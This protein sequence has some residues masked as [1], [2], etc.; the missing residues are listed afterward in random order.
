MIEHVPAQQ[1]QQLVAEGAAFIDVRTTAEFAAGHAAGSCNIP[2]A[3][4]GD[5]TGPPE[6]NT[7]FVDCVRK[8]CEPDGPVVLICHVGQRSFIAAQVLEQHGY[9]TLYNLAG[10]F[11]APRGW[12]DCSLPVSTSGTTFQQIR[13]SQGSE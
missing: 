3:E 1:A 10:G 7:E 5:G 2:I 12:L 9:S 13:L 4:P 11:G 8:R 6:F